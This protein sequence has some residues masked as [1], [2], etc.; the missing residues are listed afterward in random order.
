[1]PFADATTTGL[2][3][4]SRAV[5]LSTTEIIGVAAFALRSRVS[6]AAAAAPTP[7]NFRLEIDNFTPPKKLNSQQ[8]QRWRLPALV[9]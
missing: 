2:N 9:L 1:M 7:M 3:A 6:A 5:A 8:L 4:G